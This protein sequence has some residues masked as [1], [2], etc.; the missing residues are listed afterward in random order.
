MRRRPVLVFSAAHQRGG[1]ERMAWEA[2]NHLASLG[3]VVFVGEHLDPV[4]PGV[5]HVVVPPGRRRSAFGPLRF[6]RRATAALRRVA[7]A[8]DATVSFG[9]NCPPGDVLVVN[10]VHRTWLRRGRPAQ[11]RGIAIPNAI[12]YLLPRHLVLLGLEHR[13]FA[14]E[15]ERQV[16]VVAEQLAQELDDIYGIPAKRSIVLHNGYAAAQCSPQRRAANR[17]EQRTAWSIA[18]GTIALL[19][20]A[21]ELHR[22]GFG[23]LIEAVAATGDERFEIHVV[24]RAPLAPYA[25]RIS[26]LGLTGR[27][28]YHGSGDTG[29]AHAAADV[30]VLPTQY[31]AF[32]LTIV[33]GLASGLPV[34][35][36]TVPGAGDLIEDGRTGLLQR[37][38][39]DAAELATLLRQV[40]DPAVRDA[41][42]AAA[43]A[44]VADL[45]WSQ[46]MT[47]LDEIVQAVP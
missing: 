6:S 43:P 1:V 41:L 39:T 7:R 42:S 22:K 31:E 30:L 16:V 37:D 36:T 10:S 19:F 46:I 18:D 47:R 3:P 17:E 38:P 28:H 23:C 33:E 40:A 15:R 35:T 29:L 34:I 11:W 45:E 25:A 14:T 8:G 4:I 13:Y 12:R 24:G 26:E 21:N 44:A 9:A 27:V 32:A 2:L 5:E 20:V